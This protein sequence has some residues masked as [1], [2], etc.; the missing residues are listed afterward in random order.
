[1][2]E[3][4][5]VTCSRFLAFVEGPAYFHS[6]ATLLDLLLCLPEPGSDLLRKGRQRE[7]PEPARIPGWPKE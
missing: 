7:A 1:M 4:G 2:A 6:L 5:G 3:S